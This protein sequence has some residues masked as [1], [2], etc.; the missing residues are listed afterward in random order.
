MALNLQ[1]LNDYFVT[2][3]KAI[4]KPGARQPQAGAHLIASVR[5]CLCA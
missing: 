2:L 5:K 4:F 3:N 1:S